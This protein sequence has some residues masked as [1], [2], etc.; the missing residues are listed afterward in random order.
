MQVKIKKNKD[1]VNDSGAIEKKQDSSSK[2]KILKT[3]SLTSVVLFIVIAILF[4]L[5]FD[6]FLSGKLRWDWSQTDMFSIGEVTNQLLSDLDQEIT[7]TGLYDKGTVSQYADIELLLEEYQKKSNGNI[8]VEYIDPIK[9]P[10]I[11]KKLDPDDL[12]KPTEKSFV[13]RSEKNNKVKVLGVYDF[14]SFTYDQTTFQQQITGVTAEQAL[15]GAI[16]FVASE[17]TPVVYMTKGHG[18]A[19]YMANFN[20]MVTILKDN[21]FLVKD[22]DLLAGGEIPEDAQLLIMLSPTTDI[23][24]TARDQINSYLRS[25]KSLL[26]LTEFS[27]ASFPVL[28]S[29]LADYNI[30]ISNDRVREGE[31]ER[32][33]QDDPYVF[34]ADAPASFISEEAVN[35]RTFVR[36][37]RAISELRNV[38]EWIKVNPIL[39]TGSQ[40]VVE[41]GGDPENTTPAGISTIGLASENSGFMDGTNVKESTKVMVIGAS[42]FMGDSILSVFGTQAHNIFAF[43]YSI[44]WLIPSSEGNLLISPKQLPSY[45]LT[46]VTNTSIWVATIVTIILIPLGLLIAALVV[47]R[48]RKNL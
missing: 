6:R 25:G 4:N 42:E 2:R 45:R 7:I 32:R 36:N 48:K 28:N 26:V 12:H 23:S 43:Y 34:L 9:T 21:N 18:E 38:K 22:L 17:V 3:I 31:R 1:K 11:I 5:V 30:E 44:N 8:V 46:A 41:I 40:G 39:Q 27:N 10:S 20:T 37:P 14:F 29:L 35:A 16:L 19:D 13:V 24:T 47:F 15:S 33:F